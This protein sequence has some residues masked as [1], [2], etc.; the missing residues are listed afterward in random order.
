MHAWTVVASM[1]EAWREGSEVSD[2]D[3]THGLDEQH[4]RMRRRRSEPRE[5]GVEQ[6]I[7]VVAR[8]TDVRPDL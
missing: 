8:V 2:A 7:R 1:A 6:S 4:R 3:H 5:H